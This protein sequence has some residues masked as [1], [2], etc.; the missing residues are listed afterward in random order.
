M[1]W[2]KIKN[3]DGKDIII[4]TEFISHMISGSANGGIRILLK[5]QIYVDTDRNEI[6]KIYDALNIPQSERI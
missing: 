2:I 4:N 3:S 5:N 6:K 1:A